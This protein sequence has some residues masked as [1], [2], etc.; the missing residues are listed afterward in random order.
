MHTESEEIVASKS[1]DTRTVPAELRA[2]TA[3]TLALTGLAWGIALIAG[4]AGAG[5]PY[6]DVLFPGSPC[7]D[8]SDY[9]Q[10]FKLLHSAAFYVLPVYPWTQFPPMVFVYGFFYLFGLWG[11]LAVYVSLVLI[12]MVVGIRFVRRAL[13]RRF[14]QKGVDAFIGSL[15][16]G[17]YPI[18]FCLQR[19]NLEVI[20]AIGMALGMWAYFSRRS[21]TA[22]VLWGAFGSAKLYPLMLLAVFIKDRKYREFVI[23][24]ATGLGVTVAGLLY[25]GPSFGSAISGT[26][27]GLNK[28]LG[29]Y[30]LRYSW[31]TAGYDHSFF[32]F[33][34]M[35][36]RPELSAIPM[37][38]RVYMAV[39]TVAMV[40]T[41]FVRVRKLSVINQI[42]FFASAA[43]VLP[44]TSFDYTLVQLYAPLVALVMFVAGRNV[45]GARPLIVALAIAMTPLNFL[46]V[47][48][49]TYQGPIRS[50]VLLAVCF[51][52]LRYD[53][54]PTEADPG[55][56]RPS[57]RSTPA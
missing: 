13:L 24:T 55:H 4:F 12:A 35:C 3:V 34:K 33:L 38:L 16:I 45:S 7:T 17:A 39:V 27:A 10:P 18:E 25:L 47:H 52:A 31:D 32:S 26:L 21:T 11:G 50:L 43:V 30:A 49:L 19:G 22:A 5:S 14:H 41:Y 56:G 42:V 40:V 8:Y 46:F 6:T 20:L 9:Y 23:G 2:F 29:L 53:L 51:L 44:P 48:G 28:F 57:D 37:M 54:R 36:F 1:G 15:L